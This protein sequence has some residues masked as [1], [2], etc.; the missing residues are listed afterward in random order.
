MF[1]S[2]NGK[3]F[4]AN[5][6]AEFATRNNIVWK[7]NIARSSWRG[8]F[9]ERLVK[10]V[11]RCLRKIVGTA[12]LSYKE[13]ETVLVDISRPLTYVYGDETGEVLLTHSHLLRGRRILSKAS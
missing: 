11:K 4:K 12:R 2:D 8:G 10:S 9:F 1:I 6:L 5:E 3:T 13:M 7:F